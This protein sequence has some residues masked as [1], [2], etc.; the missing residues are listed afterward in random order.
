MMALGY[1]DEENDFLANVKKV[2]RDKEKLFIHL[3]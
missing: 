1:R 3:N 2:R